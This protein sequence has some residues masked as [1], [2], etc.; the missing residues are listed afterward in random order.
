MYSNKPGSE[1]DR[2]RLGEL[3]AGAQKGVA[4]AR[5]ECNT[6]ASG[7]G[8]PWPLMKRGLDRVQ[9]T[10]A[11]EKTCDGA[12]EIASV[13]HFPCKPQWEPQMYMQRH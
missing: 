3:P 6:Q 4:S 13:K 7:E 8:A 5:P 11:F 10:W 1:P 12:G 2:G 9:Y